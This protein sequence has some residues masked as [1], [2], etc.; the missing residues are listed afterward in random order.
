V[1]AWHPQALT[2]LRNGHH[3]FWWTVPFTTPAKSIIHVP[4]D[5]TPRSLS[6]K[7]GRRKGAIMENELQR[8]TGYHAHV[9]YEDTRSR[10]MAAELRDAIA[11]R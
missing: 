8:I 1:S 7:P 3:S 5:N 2:P 9:Y 4:A 11:A 10:A 6:P